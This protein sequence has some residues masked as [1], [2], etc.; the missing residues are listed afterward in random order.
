M[1]THKHPEM[2]DHQ[3]DTVAQ[4]QAC[5]TEWADIRWE[6]EAER[7]AERRAERYYEE[8]TSA[9]Q[10]AYQNELDQER[11]HTWPHAGD[12]GS[13]VLSLQLPIGEGR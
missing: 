8:G 4:A 3:H 13:D 9:Q 12:W 10:M 11:E 1:F 5:E 6:M 7:E 2:N